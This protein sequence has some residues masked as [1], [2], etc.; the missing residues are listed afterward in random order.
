MHAAAR[1]LKSMRT[2]VRVR[3]GQHPPRGPRRVLCLGRAARRPAA[4]RP[5]G[6]RRRRSRARGELRGEGAGRPDGDGWQA[7]APAV[8][9]GG[10]GRP[11]VLGL[12]RGEQGGVRGL[13]RHVAA[14]R[15]AVDRRGVPRRPRDAADLRDA[16]RRSPCGCGAWCSSGSGCRSRSASRGPSSSPRS[17]AASRSPTGCWWCRPTASWRSSTR[18]RSSGCGASARSPP[19]SSASAGSRP[20]ARSR[21]HAED[22][23]IALLG[24]GVGRHLHALAHNR[25]PRR[26]QVGR[27]RRSIGGQ[28]ALGRRWKSP[29]ALDAALVGL[30]DRV[31]RRLRTARRVCRTD[32]AAAAVRRLLPRHP[33][34]HAARGD[35]RDADDPRRRREACSRRRCR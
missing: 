6:D 12:R 31:T 7:G 17:P 27:R 14:G 20:S 21:E 18:S 3:R 22:A 34:A 11:A 5:P 28:R 32:R 23:L 1:Y 19:A 8:P 26:V 29:E 4:A 35:R 15:G 13:Q 25:D 9:G 2:C 10:R 24:R 33:V 16:A 30:V